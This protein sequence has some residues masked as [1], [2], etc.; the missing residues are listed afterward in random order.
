MYKGGRPTSSAW[1]YFYKVEFEDKQG[2]S[3]N[4]I[5]QAKCKRCGH[6]QSNKAE[7]MLKHAE[8]MLSVQ[9]VANAKY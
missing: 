9:S 4:K 3:I 8:K 5:V 1:K 2:R 6:V 7:R